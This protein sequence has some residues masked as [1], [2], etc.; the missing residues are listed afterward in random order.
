MSA[1]SVQ[2]YVIER[3]E[4]GGSMSDRKA[5]SI[6]I[7]YSDGLIDTAEGDAAEKI[8]AWYSGCETLAIIHGAEYKGPNFTQSEVASK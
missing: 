4:K 5:V 1:A 7:E 2:R 6:R 3:I 8:M